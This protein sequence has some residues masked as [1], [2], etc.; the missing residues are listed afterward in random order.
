LFF[1]DNVNS[2]CDQHSRRA[3]IL[4]SNSL[5]AKYTRLVEDLTFVNTKRMLE[6]VNDQIYSTREW[7]LAILSTAL[8]NRRQFAMV[9]MVGDYANDG[10]TNDFRPECEREARRPRFSPPATNPVRE[11]S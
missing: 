6:A 1:L 9:L 4:H 2:I 3:V 5:L 7:R 11:Q 8:Q 10:G